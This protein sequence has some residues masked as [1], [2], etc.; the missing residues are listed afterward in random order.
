MKVNFKKFTL[1]LILIFFIFLFYSYQ[2]FDPS[3]FSSIDNYARNVPSQYSSDIEI[4]TKY[5]VATSKND[6]EKARALWIWITDNISYD[7][8]GLYPG[9]VSNY[10][11]DSTFQNRKGVC[12]GYASLFKKMCDIANIKCEIIKGFA[13]DYKYDPSNTG[14]PKNNHVWNAININNKWYLIDATWGA[15]YTDGFSF[16]KE[17]EEF[18]FC[19]DPD[20]LLY[21]HFPEDPFW[22][23]VPNKIDLQTFFNLLYVWPQFFKLKLT[24][25][26]HPYSRI[27]TSENE[28][29]IG[30]STPLDNLEITAKLLS[31][32]KFEKIN[33]KPTV[34]VLKEDNMFRWRIY[35]KLPEPGN[36]YLNIYGAIK[37]GSVMI[38][39]IIVQ[40]YLIYKK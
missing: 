31:R 10:D 12:S 36:Y 28:L 26:S 4:L 23:L 35:V 38:L 19:P 11:A 32:D 13:K 17:Y 16:K 22:Q 15:G 9:F 37:K 30:F 3:N 25:P 21:T 5:L 1:S 24:S 14:I 8:Y 39:P 20:K 40:Y 29:T 34:F 27:Q 2:N 18:Y 7:V 6:L 33:N